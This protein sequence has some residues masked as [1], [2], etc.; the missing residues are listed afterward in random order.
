[1]EWSDT[2]GCA[3]GQICFNGNCKTI[4]YRCLSDASETIADYEGGVDPRLS[5]A[6]ANYRNPAPVINYAWTS[7]PDNDS[8]TDDI[9]YW[10]VFDDADGVNGFCDVYLSLSDVENWE[11]CGALSI[12]WYG[13]TTSSRDPGLTIYSYNYASGSYGFLGTVSRPANQGGTEVLPLSGIDRSRV[14]GFL[15]RVEQGYFSDLSNASHMQRTHIFSVSI[16][17]PTTTTTTSTTA[18][19]TT[20]SSSSTSTTTATSTSTSQA[21]TPSTTTTTAHQCVMPGNY[22]PCEG[23]TLSEVVE[24]IYE[25]V[26]GNLGL[27]ELI[28]L[29]NSWADPI[30]YPPV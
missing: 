5:V 3:G 26:E 17:A 13:W 9:N 21:T 2:I 30:G 18:T 6:C 4:S 25:W 1:L 29:I 16:Q 24:G 20:T 12:K 23:I 27:G 10:D 14:D 15:F 8:A 22:P 7:P 11:R 28:G 19:T